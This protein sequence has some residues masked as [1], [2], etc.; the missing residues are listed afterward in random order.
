[1]VDAGEAKHEAGRQRADG[2]RPVG[3]SSSA[4]GRSPTGTNTIHD[5]SQRGS[6]ASSVRLPTVIALVAPI[7]SSTHP[8][9]FSETRAAIAQP[10]PVNVVART[11]QAAM[12]ELHSVPKVSGPPMRTSS[13]KTATAPGTRRDD[14]SRPQ[15]STWSAADH[16]LG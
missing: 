10:T 6:P 7:A 14:A 8:K 9:G 11:S 15:R 13:T 4:I 16:T 12:S 2:R 1:M 5:R 3:N